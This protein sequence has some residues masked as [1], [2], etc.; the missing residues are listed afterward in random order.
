MS[1]SPLANPFSTVV[2]DSAGQPAGRGKTKD[3]IEDIFN[4]DEKADD[5]EVKD[6]KEIKKPEPKP[7]LDDEEDDDKPRDEED[8]IN[9]KDEEDLDENTEKLDL[10]DSK[11]DEIAAPPR[12]KEILKEYPDLFKKFPFIE[13]ML[14]RDREYTDLF[15]SFDNA[16]EIAGKVQELDRFE[17][18]LLSGKTESVLKSVK[19]ADPKAFDKIVDDYLP[20]LNRVDKDAYLEVC[21]NLVKN[22][23]AGMVAESNKSENEEL[24]QAAALLN[25]YVFMTSDYTPPK[26]RVPKGD[27]DK[28]DEVNRERQ[29][30]MNERFTTARDDLQIRVDNTL[31]STISEY[32]DP[33]NS[34]SE[35]EKRNAINET[36]ELVHSTIGNDKAFRTNLDRLW[37]NA[38]S[39]KFS[40]SSLEKIRSSY[41]GKSKGV[42]P[43]SIRKIRNTVLK[44]KSIKKS[45]DDEDEKET[46]RERKTQI[47]AARPAQQT[48]KRAKNERQKGETVNDFFMRD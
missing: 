11:D 3:E 1:S 33:K 47:H 37:K 12:K 25:Q 23:I 14:F 18:E 24:K 10:K 6:D 34:M 40:K 4:L 15:G 30:F 45:N 38:M 26:L 29:E 9:L 17:G 2:S 43:D 27:T 48:D 5:K 19:D 42:L 41:L 8:E 36:L 39:E 46:P 21:G 44:D 32:I 22:I 35:Y 13:K 7:K 16:K 31:K 28:D 20:A